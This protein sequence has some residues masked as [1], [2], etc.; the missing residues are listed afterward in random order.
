MICTRIYIGGIGRVIMP[1]PF[2]SN[3]VL[4]VPVQR[5]NFVFKGTAGKLGIEVAV[6]VRK[7]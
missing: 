4:F 7:S 2:S 1:M 3:A 5:Y 6:K